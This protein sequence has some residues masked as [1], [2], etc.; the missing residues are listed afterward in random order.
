VVERVRSIPRKPSTSDPVL[1]PPPDD[2]PGTPP[3]APGK[4]AGESDLGS[5]IERALADP[6]LLGAALGD[7]STWSTWLATIK[8]SR[9]SRLTPQERQLF[10]QVAGG[11]SPPARKVRE[12][13]VVVS[14][15]AGKGRIGAALAVYEAVLVDHSAKFSPGETGVVAIVSPTLDQSRIMLDYVCGYLEASPV[16]APEIELVT[17]SEVRLRNGN[18][19]VTL[20]SD[21]RSL[22]G[23]TLLTAI[24][25]EA[26]FKS[27]E[28]KKHET[29]APSRRRAPIGPSEWRTGTDDRES[30]QRQQERQ[31]A[32][33]R[34]NGIAT[35]PSPADEV[36]NGRIVD[37]GTFGPALCR[38]AVANERPPPLRAS[39]AG[40]MDAIARAPPLPGVL[41][42]QSPLPL[43]IIPCQF[44]LDLV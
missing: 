23:R 28:W 27:F 35:L 19:I 3:G 31:A 17:D 12:L 5:P 38:M 41:L 18:V 36:T 15:R 7:L 16:L 30:P 40:T 6:K 20:A 44:A 37:S 29:P 13:V 42:W 26:S 32:I 22:R 8:A 4:P 21:Y 39:P 25:D 10:D 11:R 2:S 24:L 33:A 43:M 34:N 9:G 14:R 1:V